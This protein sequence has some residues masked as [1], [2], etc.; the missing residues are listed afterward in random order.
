MEVDSNV[1]VEVTVSLL[2]LAGVVGL[3][4]WRLKYKKSDQSGTGAAGGRDPANPK[5]SK[6]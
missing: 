6:K 2:V 1:A 5:E 3:I 4:Y